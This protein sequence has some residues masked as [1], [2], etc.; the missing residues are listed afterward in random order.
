[1][2]KRTIWKTNR[3]QKWRKKI[4]LWEKC[5]KFTINRIELHN[6]SYNVHYIYYFYS[7]NFLYFRNAFFVHH[8]FTSLLFFCCLPMQCN[9]MAN[10]TSL[11][12]IISR[13]SCWCN[14]CSTIKCNMCLFLFAFTS[15]YALLLFFLSIL[16]FIRWNSNISNVCGSLEQSW[17][18]TEARIIMSCSTLLC[19][20]CSCAMIFS[21]MWNFI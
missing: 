7:T 18:N 9:A 6:D 3:K 4:A 1:M 16:L 19:S 14:T 13:N 20:V 10:P 2:Q 5:S 8:E 11:P 21:Y 17:K 15:A 12:F